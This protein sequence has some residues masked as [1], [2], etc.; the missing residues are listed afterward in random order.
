MVPHADS[1]E[2]SETRPRDAAR[3]GNRGRRGFRVYRSMSPY[4]LGAVY[5]GKDLPEPYRNDDA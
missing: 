5:N 3:G 2:W 4:I 1:N